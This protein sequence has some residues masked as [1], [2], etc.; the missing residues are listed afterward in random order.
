MFKTNDK[1]GWIVPDGTEIPACSVVPAYSTLGNGCKLGSNCSWLGVESW[2]TLANVDGSGRQVKHAAGVK[3][4]AGALL[5]KFCAKAAAENKHRYA[6]VIQ[7]V[8]EVM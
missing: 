6:A 3:V 4:E 5:E 7:A 2:L 8:A 1:G